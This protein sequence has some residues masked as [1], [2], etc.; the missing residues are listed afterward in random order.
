MAVFTA[1]TTISGVERSWAPPPHPLRGR[2]RPIN[3]FPT[4]CKHSVDTAPPLTMP[5]TQ[6][7]TDARVLNSQ[8]GLAC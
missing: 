6:M 3:G 7:R 4:G 1:A 2:N 5:L 8:V